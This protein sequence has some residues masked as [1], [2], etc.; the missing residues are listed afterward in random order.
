[1]GLIPFL[2]AFAGVKGKEMANGVAKALVSIDPDG[3]TEAD[4][5]VMEQDL[6]RAGNTISKLKSELDKER[7]VFDQLNTQYTRLLSTAEVLQNQIA[8]PANG[9]KKASLEASL[10]TLLSKIESVVPE[11]DSDKHDV[12]S[13]QSLLADSETAYKEKAEA[14]VNARKNLERSKHDLEHAKLEESRAKQRADTAAEVAG[15][16]QNSTNGL[17]TA[18]DLMKKSA[19]EA[20]QRAAASERKATELVAAK[21]G[22]DTDEDPNIKAAM[23]QASGT[24]TNQSLSDR[25]ASLKNR[26]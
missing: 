2:S 14:L 11:L 25:L 1:M 23:A 16:R 19:D 13:T 21:T 4:L 12:E 24:A 17:T 22:G 8:D 7:V 5:A 20:R 6:D 18:L 10:A 9:A 26:S 15:L 3:A